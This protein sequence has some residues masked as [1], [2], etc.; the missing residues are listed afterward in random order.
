MVMLDELVSAET[1]GVHKL[2][3]KVSSLASLCQRA[4][5]R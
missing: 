3:Y 5:D 4:R 1:A 2:S